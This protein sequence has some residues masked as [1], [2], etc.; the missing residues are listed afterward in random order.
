MN[1]Q[2]LLGFVP[3][4]SRVVTAA[5]HDGEPVEVAV[6]LKHV[7]GTFSDEV[8]QRLAQPIRV[9]RKQV[10]QELKQLY[11]FDRVAG[12]QGSQ[13]AWWV[14]SLVSSRRRCPKAR[15]PTI[16]PIS[17]PPRQCQTRWPAAGWRRAA[18]T[19]PTATRPRPNAT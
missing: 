4:Q 16:Q 15:T 1:T 13:R 9:R 6:K 7:V 8:A 3:E 5:E 17:T 2:S 11:E 10:L 18:P 12:L 19:P 14:P